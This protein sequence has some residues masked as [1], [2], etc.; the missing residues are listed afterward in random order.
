M[1][2]LPGAGMDVRPTKG[3]ATFAEP[4]AA[5]LAQRWLG[6][7]RASICNQTGR[8]RASCDISRCHSLAHSRQWLKERQHLPDCEYDVIGEINLD[9]RRSRD[10]G[11]FEDLTA[12]LQLIA[13]RF[14]VRHMGAFAI[15]V[16]ADLRRYA[17]AP[18]QSG[19]NFSK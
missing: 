11:N 14:L 9:R 3:R 6:N 12:L 19:Q 15:D 13:H 5:D 1:P 18:L 10:N 7:A 2:S 4:Q 8:F 17:P 16:G